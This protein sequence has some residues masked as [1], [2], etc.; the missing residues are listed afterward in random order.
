MS[1]AHGWAT[2]PVS[3]LSLAILGVSPTD[4]ASR[5]WAVKPCPGDLLHAEGQ[6]LLD[7]QAGYVKVTWNVKPDSSTA[8]AVD[9]DSASL[10]YKAS[11]IG[12][13]YVPVSNASSVEISVNGQVAWSNGKFV[14]VPSISSAES[15][16]DGARVVFMGVT[17][18]LLRIRCHA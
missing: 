11:A 13:I 9:V 2:G 14:P 1:N 7:G 15:D 17:P 12:S 4:F 18:S 10:A 8:F 6:L 3:A 5:A 16:D